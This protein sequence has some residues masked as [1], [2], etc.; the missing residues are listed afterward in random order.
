M[1]S[2]A[3]VIGRAF[4][5]H[6]LSPRLSP[7]KTWEGYVGGL[8]S[9]AFFSGLFSLFWNLGAG[10]HSLLTWQTGAVL[11]ALVGLL[12]PLGD[13]GVSM[14]KRQTGVKDTGDVMA[15]HGGVLDRIDSWLVAVPVGYYFVMVLQALVR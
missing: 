13:L 3:Y 4:G 1:D 5:R 7:K 8:L 9:G 15:G 10:P 2:G 14:L 6:K 11:G 12:S